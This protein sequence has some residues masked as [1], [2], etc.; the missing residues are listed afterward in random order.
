MIVETTNISVAPEVAAKEQVMRR[1]LREMQSVI[2]AFSGGVDSAYLAYI[3][4]RELGDRALAVTGESPSY[5]DFQRQDALAVVQQFAIPHETIITE[6]LHDPNYQ[7]NPTNRCYFCKHELFDKLTALAKTRG[8]AFVCD[9]NNADD[10]GDYRPG[11]KAAAELQVRSPLIEANLTKAD[12][13]VLAHAAGLPMWDRPASACLS[14]RIPY[15]LP[16]TIQKLS[17]I[18]RGEAA[19]RRLGFHQM[20]VRHHEQIARIEIAPDELPRA[21][22]VDM[23]RKIVEAFKRIG[24]KYIALDLEGYRQGALNEVLGA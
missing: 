8:F 15:G 6:E 13:R 1:L 17:D 20:R 16:V 14:S 2:I 3:A 11:R 7:A 12:I 5:P 10:M 21:L 18:E 4:A 22:N 23:S 19:L 24:F 9:G